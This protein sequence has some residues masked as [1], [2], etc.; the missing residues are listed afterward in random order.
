MS[1]SHGWEDEVRDVIE[2]NSEVDMI[3]HCG[4]SELDRD[5]SVFRNVLVVK[6]NCDFGGDFPEEVYETID[7]VSFYVTHGH[8]YN[9]KMTLERI[10]YRGEEK[11]ATIVCFGHTHIATCFQ[12]NGVVYINPGSLRLPVRPKEQTYCICDVTNESITVQYFNRE[13]IEVSDFKKT[14][15]R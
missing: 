15:I 8:L 9:V 5:S 1:D 11:N 14:F 2:I 7:D 6:G 3:I 13:G 12:Q 10:T 4:D